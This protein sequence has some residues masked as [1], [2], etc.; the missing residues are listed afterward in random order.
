[1]NNSIRMFKLISLSTIMAMM[2]VACSGGASVGQTA[3]E[4]I[5]ANS[6]EVDTQRELGVGETVTVL[7]VVSKDA[8][9]IVIHADNNGEPGAI[10][11]YAPVKAGL[12][13]NIKVKVDAGKLTPTLYAILHVD[14]GIQG[15]FEFPGE[16]VPA[17]GSEG[18]AAMAN[19]QIGEIPE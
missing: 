18:G 16:D 8:G 3:K 2:L 13:E 12:N 14:R 5:T 17:A 11:G 15:T 1:M 4:L 6:V 9:W 10:V 7:E 19:F